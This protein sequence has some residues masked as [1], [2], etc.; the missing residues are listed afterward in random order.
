MK[1]RNGRQLACRVRLARNA[2]NR[3]QSLGGN[4]EAATD[5]G[6]HELQ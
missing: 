4:A 1:K 2:M 6:R 5:H 3:S